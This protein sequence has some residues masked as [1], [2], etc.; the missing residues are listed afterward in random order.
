MTR[1]AE[2]A[3]DQATGK[4]A[5]LYDT[6]QKTFGMIPNAFRAMSISPDAL[7][8]HWRSIHYYQHHPSL[9][10]KLLTFIRLLVSQRMNCDYCINL[11][12]AILMR[13]FGLTPKQIATFREEPA[14]TPLT[15]RERDMLLFVLK[16]TRDPLSVNAAD[17]EHLRDLGYH[18]KD[19]FD[20][21]NLGARQVGFDILLMAFQV[22]ND[23]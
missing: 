5:E 17:I 23:F 20:A 14:T 2:V 13:E 1:L 4:V 11:N 15:V 8:Q 22:E 3:P 21:L 12:T 10:A 16:G 9:S 7:E 18:D 6:F 19:I